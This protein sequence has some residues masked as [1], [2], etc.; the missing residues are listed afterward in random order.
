MVIGKFIK[1]QN[2]VASVAMYNI[3][4]NFILLPTNNYNE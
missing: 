3:Y 1:Q 4:P 2:H